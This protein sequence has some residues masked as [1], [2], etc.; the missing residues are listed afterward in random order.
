M[1]KYISIDSEN[2][3]TETKVHMNNKD[4]VLCGTFKIS[5][6]GNDE[7]VD[8]KDIFVKKKGF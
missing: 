1:Q 5:E 6:N 4:N 8:I 3:S 7:L 2:N